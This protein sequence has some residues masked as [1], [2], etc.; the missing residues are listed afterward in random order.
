MRRHAPVLLL[1]IGVMAA[2]FAGGYALGLRATLIQVSERGQDDLRLGIDRLNLQLDR[3]RQL[4]AILSRQ[5]EVVAALAAPTPATVAAANAELQRIADSSGA[6]DI[7]AMDRTGMTVSASNWD[8]DRNF[9]GQNFA[10][11]PYFREASH[12][13]LASYHAVGTTSGQRGFYFAHPVRD[14]RSR[15][16]GALAVKVDLERIEAAWRGDPEILMFED[17]NGVIFLA[18]RP[19]LILR[20]IG[21]AA[22]TLADPQQYASR[23]P[24]P[25]PPFRRGTLFGHPVWRGLEVERVPSSVLALSVPVPR[26]DMTAHILVDLAP[27][28]AQGLLWGVLAATVTG[29]LFLA[30]MILLQRRRSF[31]AQL[32]VEERARGQLELRVAERTEEL[33]EAN[34]RLRQE[35]EERRAVETELRQVQDQLVQAGKLKALGEMSAGISHELNQPLAAIQSL[36]DN[37]EILMERGDNLAVVTNIGRISELAARMGRII[38]NLRAFARKEDEA[39][40]DVDLVSVVGDAIAIAAGRARAA[41]AEIVWVP[42]AAP[43]LVRGGRVRLQQVVVNLLSNAVDAVESSTG[44]RRVKV[45]LAADAARARLS[46]CDAGPGLADPKRIFDPFYTTKQ[47]GEGLGLGLSISYGIVQSFGGQISG[48]NRP[49]GGA[50]FVVELERAKERRAA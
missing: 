7:Y 15:T 9:V 24:E 22:P 23:T 33:S 28:R 19:A 6:L 27:A 48:R 42:P 4:P 49:E 34:R 2:A 31:A 8:L 16:L 46:V 41:E 13:N 39:V 11:R 30:G 38:R 10:F 47:V 36:A 35:V 21:G 12:G 50:E 43:V 37:A 5:A 1:C 20:R 44:S 18:N 3:F 17:E 32:A 25:L 26:L 40:V 14:H 29:L 45:E